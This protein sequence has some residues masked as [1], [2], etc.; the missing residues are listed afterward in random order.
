M[1]IFLLFFAC[2]IRNATTDATLAEALR[3]A[4]TYTSVADIP[5]SQ[6][7]AEDALQISSEQLRSLSSSETAPPAL[8]GSV[9]VL[10]VEEEELVR[11]RPPRTR[12]GWSEEMLLHVYLRAMGPYFNY[13][14]KTRSTAL[15]ERKIIMWIFKCALQMWNPECARGKYFEQTLVTKIKTIRRERPNDRFPSLIL[16][17]QD[18]TQ[19][20][21]R[22]R[23]KGES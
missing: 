12:F 9:D 15:K 18:R 22:W 14:F 5:A 4:T 23:R 10:A 7:T 2:S 11:K 3:N 13:P 20:R 21:R 16:P 1:I 6:P 8:E 19:R 17:A